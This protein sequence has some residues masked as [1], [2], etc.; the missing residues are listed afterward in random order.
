VSKYIVTG[1]AGFIG[2]NLVK[3]L[4]RRGQTVKVIDDLSTGRKANL[5]DVISQIEFVKGDITDLKLLQKEFKGWDF[6]LHQAAFISVPGSIMAPLESNETNITGTLNV[7]IAARDQKI[8]RVVLASSTAVYGDSLPEIKKE[9]S[10][11][12][13]LSPYA[14]H[15]AVNESYAQLFYK[16]Y[17]LETVCLRYFNVFGPNQDP[18][19]EYAAVIPKFITAMLRDERPVVFGDGLQ[20]RDFNYV[21]NNVEANILAS[22]AKGAAGEVFNIASGQSMT[23]LE[24]IAVINQVLGKNIQPTY[25]KPRLG[26]IKISKANITKAKKILGN[27]PVVSFQKGLSKTIDWYKSL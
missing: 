19:S 7:L 20:S 16:L 4:V 14:L 22:Q 8:K 12:C 24:L 6:V 25:K 21:F 3:E 1:G 17:G 9:D 13:P 26:D 11:L 15:K 18:K 5:K 27:K 23:L 10:P 2:S